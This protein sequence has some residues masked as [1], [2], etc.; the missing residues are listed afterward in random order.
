MS[1]LLA[2]T[3]AA[4]AILFAYPSLAADIQNEDGTE[5]TV[6]IAV[7][8]GGPQT[9]KLAPGK[10]LKGVC[11]EIC[12]VQLESGP[13]A[14]KFVATGDDRDVVVIRDGRIMLKPRG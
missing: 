13:G 7:G 8:D 6:T 3:A 2:T 12:N 5:H 4:A 10:S 14:G 9:M 11:T 1:K